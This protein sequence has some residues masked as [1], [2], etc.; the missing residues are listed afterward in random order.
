M[1]KTSNLDNKKCQGKPFGTREARTSLPL[2]G[3]M[4][5][6][7]KANAV[8]PSEDDCHFDQA[9]RAEK[10]Q[11]KKGSLD[12]ARDDKTNNVIPSE[13]S[14]SSVSQQLQNKNVISTGAEKSPNNSTKAVKSPKSSSNV[15]EGEGP[16][17]LKKS[18]SILLSALIVSLLLSA[19]A[20]VLSIFHTEITGDVKSVTAGPIVEFYQREYFTDTNGNGVWDSGE[21][22]VD[23]NEN[24]VYDDRLYGLWLNDEWKPGQTKNYSFVVTNYYLPEFYEDT[25]GN[26]HYDEGEPYSDHNRNSKYDGTTRVTDVTM[27]YTLK[28]DSSNM[29]P[30]TYSL[31][32]KQA[33]NDVNTNT[34]WQAIQTSSTVN[35]SPA[36]A[37][38]K[39]S[40]LF[41]RNLLKI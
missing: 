12:C 17:K 4:S 22:Y 39:T 18:T 7:N 10:S 8:I 5:A 23:V 29:L 24:G 37:F 9:K 3:D 20:G 32:Q 1:D 16:K 15:N 19:L 6:S 33:N 11:Q 2:E 38:L 25:N 28:I 21:A 13:H 26:G 34:N 40:S 41:I 27:V 35:P 14:E 31:T 30:L 36:S